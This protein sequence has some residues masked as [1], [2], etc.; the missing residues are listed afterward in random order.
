MRA[1][2]RE[3]M[4]GSLAALLEGLPAESV[5]LVVFNLDQQKTLFTRD[6]FRSEQLGQVAQSLN[7]LQL[8]TVDYGVL[9]NR[10][11]HLKLL[12]EFINAELTQKEI[13]DA[14]I[15]LG[16]PTR[17]FDKPD[18]SEFEERSAGDPQ[19]FYL[20]YRPYISRRAELPDSIQHAVRR[21]KGKT[22]V[23]H[24]PGEFANAIRQVETRLKERER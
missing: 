19:F 10:A 18:Q 3:M 16:P 5:R 9:Q 22:M 24:T 12:T 13:P 2:D 6:H 1:F 11:G 8:G 17:H 15:F 4:L 21:M 14:V 23:V 7:Q 20:Q